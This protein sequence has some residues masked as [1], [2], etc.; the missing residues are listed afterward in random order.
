MHSWR[1]TIARYSGGVTAARQSRESVERELLNEAGFRGC[2]CS[3]DRP[4]LAPRDTSL[5]FPLSSP[6]P[7]SALTLSL[8]LSSFY[9]LLPS[10]VTSFLLPL[11]L[12]T[13]SIHLAVSSFCRLFFFHPPFSLSLFS[14]HPFNRY[15][16]VFFLPSFSRSFPRSALHLTTP[17]NVQG[18]LPPRPDRQAKPSPSSL[19][20][21][22]GSS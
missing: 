12:H 10:R 1:G 19:S 6:S 13:F 7:S 22:V 15:P 17:R 20:V 18:Q 8:S 11:K 2:S 9:P 3:I 14:L 4:T 16:F 5:L 21:K